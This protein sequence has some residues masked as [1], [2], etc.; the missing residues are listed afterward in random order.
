MI[1]GISILSTAVLAA[2][3]IAGLAWA[4]PDDSSSSASSTTSTTAAASTA[5]V[6]QSAIANVTYEAGAAGLVT[7]EQSGASLS[8]SQV[9]ANTDWTPEVEM[10]S[11]REVEV[12]FVNG[13]QRIDFH[14]EL[15][16]GMVKT[17]VRTRTLDSSINDSPDDD[18]MTLTAPTAA[19]LQFNAGEAGIVLIS[20]ANGSLELVSA[21]PNTGWTVADIEIE[22]T[23]EIN[24]EFS[25]G[26]T[27]IEFKAEFEDGRVK[28]RVRTEMNDDSSNGNSGDEDDSDDD[29]SRKSDSGD[30]RSDHSDDRDDDSF[31]D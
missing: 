23:R 24:V 18:N 7:V 4:T 17:R 30:D 8:I 9:A 16:D 11:G 29:H 28:T 3:L 5:A 21:T 31:D 14:A 2:L 19:E 27:E 26:T 15:E 6:S 22:G 10:A 25:N 13:N 1:K 12:K 20:A